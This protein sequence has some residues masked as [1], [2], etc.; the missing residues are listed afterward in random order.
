MDENLPQNSIFACDF[1]VEKI[2]LNPLKFS[3]KC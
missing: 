3:T 2:K 1:F